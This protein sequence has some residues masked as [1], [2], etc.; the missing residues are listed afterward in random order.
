[1]FIG[2]NRPKVQSL[3][4]SL[5]RR[6]AAEKV[7]EAISSNVADIDMWAAHT[8]QLVAMLM[9]IQRT[10]EERERAWTQER[11][12]AATETRDSARRAKLEAALQAGIVVGEGRGLNA[13]FRKWVAAAGALGDAAG[14]ERDA[15]A[16][17][18][19]EKLARAGRSAMLEEHTRLL[20]DASQ[21]GG[22]VQAMQAP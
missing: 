21:A 16:M 17:R 5:T 4:R 22:K 10:G 8:H 19:T 18:R 7:S 13:S 3:M 12:A 2:P 15:R 14:A 20:K 11:A 6:P 1:V 9:Q